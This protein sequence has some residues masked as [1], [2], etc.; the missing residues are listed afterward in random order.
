MN[1]LRSFLAGA[2]AAAT[3]GVALASCGG[4]NREDGG[5]GSAGGVSGSVRVDGS[6]TVGPLTEVIAELFNEENPDARITVGTSGTGG[7]FER[8]CAGETDIN[9]ASRQV[10]PEETAACADA[11]IAFDEVTVATDAL[12]VVVHHDNP[13]DCLTV[14]QLSQIWA[15]DSQIANWHEVTGLEVDFNERLAPFGPGT[16]SGTFDYFSDVINGAEGAHR[17]DYNNAGED[18][19]STVVGVGGT[20]GGIGYFGFSFFEENQDQLKALEIENPETGDCVAPSVETAQNGTYAPLSRPLF[21]YASAQALERPEVQAFLEFYLDNL[22]QAAIQ[23][24]F[25]PLTEDQLAESRANLE[26]IVTPP[27]QAS[28]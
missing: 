15:R 25:I 13:V 16:D 23:A 8:F 21:I 12:T 6:S 4:E 26:S 11:G 22:D 3:V 24:G 18:D 2:I 14:A 10:K 20:P 19:S 17:V 9:D 5:A 28:S 27:K 7:G 1:T